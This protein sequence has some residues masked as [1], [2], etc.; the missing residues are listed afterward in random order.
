MYWTGTLQVKLT[1]SS[2]QCGITELCEASESTLQT[3]Y[4]SFRQHQD[5]ARDKGGRTPPTK[6]FAPLEKYIRHSLKIIGHSLK[7]LVPS[8]K[9]LR[10][11][12]DSSWLRVWLGWTQ[13]FCYL[14]LPD[15]IASAL[16]RQARQKPQLQVYSS[17]LDV[18]NGQVTTSPIATG[19][20]W[21]AYSPQTKLQVPPN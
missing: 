15:N 6:L 3:G 8:Q 18:L 12:G 16:A 9:T 11:P 17:R 14:P 13:W 2:I 19:G 5:Q 10:P 20:L 4:A 7:N 1:T 21:W